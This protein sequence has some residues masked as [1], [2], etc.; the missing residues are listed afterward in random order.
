MRYRKYLF[1]SLAGPEITGLYFSN[2]Q[3]ATWEDFYNHDNLIVL[4]VT[5]IQKY[6]ILMHK[7]YL[8]LE[9]FYVMMCPLKRAFS[10]LA[11]YSG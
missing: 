7:L 3:Y 2:G 10:W 5:F 6:R 1:K 8:H 4:W 11:F 9:A